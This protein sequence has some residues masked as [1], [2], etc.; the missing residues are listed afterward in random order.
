MGCEA[1]D[2]DF[3]RRTDRTMKKIN[4]TR[5]EAVR[6]FQRVELLPIHAKNSS[7][8]ARMREI[9]CRLRELLVFAVSHHL[10]DA[11]DGLRRHAKRSADFGERVSIGE[12]RDGRDA[13]PEHETLRLC[14]EFLGDG[15]RIRLLARRRKKLDEFAVERSNRLW[16]QLLFGEVRHGWMV[17]RVYRYD[18][19]Y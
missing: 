14:E 8:P 19:S 9:A 16:L 6:D 18:I 13:L 2:A 1:R 17:M 12:H 3:H 10:E 11:A 7:E 4:G 5:N 15:A